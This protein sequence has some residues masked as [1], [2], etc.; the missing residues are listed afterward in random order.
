MIDGV[1]DRV[2]WIEAA[3]GRTRPSRSTLYRKIREGSFGLGQNQCSM[4]WLA[5]SI[6]N[7]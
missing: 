2:L 7:R 3:L 5:E 4:L 6:V 1:P